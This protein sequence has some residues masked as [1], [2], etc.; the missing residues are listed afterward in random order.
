M[1]FKIWFPAMAQHFRA[2][3]KSLFLSLSML[4]NLNVLKYFIRINFAKSNF[5]ISQF[6]AL[7]AVLNPLRIFF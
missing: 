4:D 2:E 7:F 6:F 1:V 5:V 3:K